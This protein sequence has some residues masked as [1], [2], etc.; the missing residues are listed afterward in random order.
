MAMMDM[1]EMA[2]AMFTGEL[3]CKRRLNEVKCDFEERVGKAQ[4]A[5]FDLQALSNAI[6]LAKKAGYDETLLQERARQAIDESLERMGLCKPKNVTKPRPHAKHHA[7]PA[8]N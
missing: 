1:N 2:M 7:K 3:D 8:G 6:D 5:M 4:T